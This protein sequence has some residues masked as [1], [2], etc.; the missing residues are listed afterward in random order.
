MLFGECLAALVATE[1]L[2]AVSVLPETRAGIAA[3]MAGHGF[4][5]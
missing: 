1:P 4:A 3:I 2:E 5:S